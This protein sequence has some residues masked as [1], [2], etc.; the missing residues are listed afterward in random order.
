[1]NNAIIYDA[2]TTCFVLHPDGLVE[3]KTCRR[4]NVNDKLLF[5]I[6]RK[7]CWIK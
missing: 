3:V 6:D 4:D 2:P 1:M 5:A 7:I